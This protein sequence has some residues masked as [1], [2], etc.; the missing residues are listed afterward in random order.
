MTSDSTS[1]PSPAFRAQLEWEV[2][3]AFRREARLGARSR[4]PRRRLLH[5]ATLVFVS[6]A[7]GATAGLAS[8][9]VRDSA[10]RDSLLE[11]AKAEIALTKLRLQLAQTTFGEE[12]KKAKVGA[13]SAEALKQAETELRAM[14]GLLAKAQ[15]N[16][17]EIGATS[18]AARDE[19]NAPLVNGRD[20]VLERIQFD[21]RDAQ[22][23]LVAAEA[24]YSNMDSRFR[25]GMA[26]EVARAEAQFEVERARRSLALLA[27]RMNLRREFVERGTSAEQLTTRLGVTE[28]RLDALLAQQAL[29]LARLRLKWTELQRTTGAAAEV[30]VL[31]AQVEVKE[32][33]AQLQR[34]AAQLQ[35][36]SRT[37]PD[38]NR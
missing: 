28:V 7:V 19:L 26:T 34:L 33:E 32:L 10:R 35:R 38:S 6:V 24:A 29:E 22:Q 3:R 8:S 37:P 27:E 21:L 20:F 23:Q 16:I 14:E 17:E 1:S 11:A 15:L 4:E 18:L 25:T 5:E 2:T 13:A 36:L 12:M 31:R 30:D 9:Q